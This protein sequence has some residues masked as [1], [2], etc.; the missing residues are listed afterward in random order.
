M[1]MAVHAPLEGG[2]SSVFQKG[3][4]AGKSVFLLVVTGR[5]VVQMTTGQR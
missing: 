4:N 1:N 5:Q 3:M 2:T